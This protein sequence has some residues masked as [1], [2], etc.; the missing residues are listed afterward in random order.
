LKPVKYSSPLL[1]Y[2]PSMFG[3]YGESKILDQVKGKVPFFRAESALKPRYNITPTQIAPI[4]VL[5]DELV[6]G[7]FPAQNPLTASPPEP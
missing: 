4:I 7:I 3:R 2:V 5:Q 6:P 1:V